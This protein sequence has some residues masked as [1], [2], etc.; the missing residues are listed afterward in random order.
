[1]AIPITEIAND[2]PN[3]HRPSSIV[4]RRPVDDDR[5]CRESKTT[6]LMATEWLRIP[7]DLITN[8]VVPS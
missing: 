3:H 6:Y 8:S 1:M 7:I 4:H 5:R 2:V